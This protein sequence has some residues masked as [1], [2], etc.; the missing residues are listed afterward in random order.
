MK[1]NVYEDEVPG[2]L[3]KHKE[4]IDLFDNLLTILNAGPEES[5]IEA[6]CR[7]MRERNDA[8]EKAARV[9][10]DHGYPMNQHAVEWSK[11]FAQHIRLLKRV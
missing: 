11:H 2:I 5:A 9:V 8:Y 7:V 3:A 6:A 4:L 1:D 10:E